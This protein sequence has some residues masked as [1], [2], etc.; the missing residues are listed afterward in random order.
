MDR[1]EVFRKLEEGESFIQIEYLNPE[2]IMDYL[3]KIEGPLG[4]EAQYF[5]TAYNGLYARIVNGTFYGN[6]RF[7]RE[8]DAG[9]DYLLFAANSPDARPQHIAVGTEVDG[10]VYFA[11]EYISGSKSVSTIIVPDSEYFNR[12]AHGFIPRTDREHIYVFTE[13][14]KISDRSLECIEH[15][16]AA[17]ER[18]NRIM[19]KCI[20]RTN[21]R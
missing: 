11:S 8:E 12:L 19:A 17:S 10:K 4:R 2:M 7:Y 3:Y 9:F 13:P 18:I 14:D 15:A 1:K 20:E 16:M 21:K 5:E 6:I